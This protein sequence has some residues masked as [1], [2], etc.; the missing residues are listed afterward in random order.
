[1]EDPPPYYLISFKIE[2]NLHLFQPLHE[3]CKPVVVLQDSKAWW[4]WPDSA[5]FDNLYRPIAK[6]SWNSGFQSMAANW[7]VFFFFLLLSDH[8][9]LVGGKILILKKE[10]KKISILILPFQFVLLN[11]LKRKRKN[12]ISLSQR[13]TWWVYIIKSAICYG[14]AILLRYH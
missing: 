7:S 6:R 1:M 11:F 10:K 5:F 4:A 2:R 9:S 12:T 13:V 8:F 14:R 3:C